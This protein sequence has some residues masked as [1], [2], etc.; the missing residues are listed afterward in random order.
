MKCSECGS[1]DI[2]KDL[3]DTYIQDGKLI[4]L[5]KLTCNKCDWA[6]NVED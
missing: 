3:V 1:T 2:D 6:W 5:F 4:K